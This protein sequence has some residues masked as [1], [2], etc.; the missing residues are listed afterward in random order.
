MS[1]KNAALL[2][3]LLLVHC[4]YPTLAEQKRHYTSFGTLPEKGQ[5]IIQLR[6]SQARF[7]TVFDDRGQRESIASDVDGLDLNGNFLPFLGSPEL[8]LGIIDLDLE[9]EI[10]SLELLLGFGLTDRISVGAILPFSRNCTRTQ[11]TLNGANVGPSAFFDASQ[12]ISA[13]NLPFLP[14]GSGASQAAG[15]DDLQQVLTQPAFGLEYKPLQDRCRSG[16]DDPT[17]G[18]VTNL[19]KSQVSSLLLTTA[20]RAGWGIEDDPDDLFD[21]SVSDGST[22]F[23]LQ[24]DYYHFFSSH[25]EFHGSINR[26]WQFSD[27]IRSRVPTD[28]SL[29]ATKASRE[30]LKRN[31][32]DYWE[33]EAEL[34]YYFHD[35]YLATSVYAISKSSD[36]YASSTGQDTFF[37]QQDTDVVDKEWTLGLR[38]HPGS[39]SGQG[40]PLILALKYWRSFD[41]KNS[42]EI[43]YAEFSAYIPF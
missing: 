8:T 39:S 38:W 3:G 5:G 33:A 14:V 19:F 16:M 7:D 25:I 11:L 12:P 32:G 4:V 23:W 9:V 10:N 20:V 1:N 31:L 6:A 2:T 43:R 22:D 37:L 17:F 28:T 42:P 41:G 36:H 21:Y 40:W 35:W 24:L 13:R 27:H 30:R 34:G 15:V 26:T 18:V 29:I